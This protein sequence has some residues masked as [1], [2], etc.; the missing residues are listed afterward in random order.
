MCCLKAVELAAV[1]DR[2]QLLQ[3]QRHHINGF[4]LRGQTQVDPADM[5]S[6]C[7]TDFIRIFCVMFFHYG[8]ADKQFCCIVGDE[9]CPYLYLDGVRFSGMEV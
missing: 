3:K 4:C 5:G 1:T 6:P 2:D 9:L 7:K 8:M